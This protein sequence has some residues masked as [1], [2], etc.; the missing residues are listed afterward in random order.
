MDSPAAVPTTRTLAAPAAATAAARPDA[1]GQ[2]RETAEALLAEGRPAD[3]VDFVLTALAAVLRSTRELELLVARLRRGGHRSERTTAEQLGFLL[4]QLA[5]LTPAPAVDPAAEARDDA[6]LEQEI[7]T[8]H[9]RAAQ[10]AAEGN[11]PSPPRRARDWA[12]PGAPRVRHHCAVPAA[13]R[14]CATC[15]RPL[16]P[17]GAD[18]TYMLEYVPG[19]FEE[20]AYVL[21]KLACGRCKNAVTT[22]AGPEKV[23]ERSAAGASTLARIIVSK[24]ADHLPLTRQQRIYARDGV[25]IPVSTLADWVAGV[26]EL[27]APLTD[28]LAARARGAF[29]VGTDATGLRVLDPQSPAH[30]ELG[31]IWCVVGDERDVS[32]HYAET[33][34]GEDG[35]WRFLQGRRGYLQADAASV[36]DRL[37]NGKEAAAIEVGCWAH[38]RRKFI[39]LQETDCRV[40]YPIM[41]MNRLY[42][43]ERLGDAKRLGPPERVELRRERCPPVLDKLGYWLAATV[44]AEPPASELAK[45]ARYV[46]NQWQ[47]LNRFLEDGRLKLD[48]NLCEQQLRAIAL[49]RHNY[50]FAGSH[51]AAHRAARLYSLVRTCALHGVAPLPYLTDVLPKLASRVYS[52]R[53]ED[54]LP[55][56]WQAV[57]H[58]I[59]QS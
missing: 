53:L 5:A 10:A 50:L 54:L 7:E 43:I 6:A 25:T 19:H 42:R 40:S 36:F 59:L 15:G 55:D 4:E 14:I 20:H 27:V 31:T 17:M 28:V 49:G 35:P 47:A 45:A 23:L 21:E 2:A 30:I 9:A 32:Y 34:R 39:A 58:G 12:A 29:V 1:L 37:Y 38:S 56:R 3:A 13:A 51:A 24:Y 16:R 41:L 18:E 26:G 44:N 33:G 11:A 22:A 48:N 52:D 46:V 57:Q 8:E